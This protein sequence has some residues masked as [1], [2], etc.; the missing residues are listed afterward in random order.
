MDAS[1]LSLDGR[2]TGKTTFTAIVFIIR[3][4]QLS[5]SVGAFNFSKHDSRR[6][7]GISVDFKRTSISV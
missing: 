3:I 5:A 4:V 6:I 1:Q 7:N 2:H